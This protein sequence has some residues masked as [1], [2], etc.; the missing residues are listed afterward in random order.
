LSDAL[1][2]RRRKETK[3]P[4]GLVVGYHLPWMQDFILA[5]HVPTEA[6]QKLSSALNSGDTAVAESAAISL[7]V[8]QE[9]ATLNEWV[10]MDM[11]DDLDGEP[12][13]LTPETIREYLDEEEFRVL[14][15]IGRRQ[16]DPDSG[17]VQRPAS[18]PS[19][20]VTLAE[21]TRPSVRSTA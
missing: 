16:M 14:A 15:A 11:V 3:L 2:L 21:P 9:S 7:D 13:K 8:I 1:K 6:L 17:E 20:E 12:V 5:G 4:T 10:V 18:P 19:S